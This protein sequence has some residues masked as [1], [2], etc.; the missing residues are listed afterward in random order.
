MENLTL[1]NF[2]KKV[3]DCPSG[4]DRQFKGNKPAIV[5]FYADWCAPCRA[6]SPVLEQLSV[7]YPDID[8]YKVNI[9]DVNEVAMMFKIRS[10]PSLLFIPVNG[11]PQTLVGALPKSTIEATI[12][13]ILINK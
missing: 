7:E 4:D 2:N 3:Y 11:K 9:D 13:K 8:F 5:D 12:K 6:I 10:I 1:E